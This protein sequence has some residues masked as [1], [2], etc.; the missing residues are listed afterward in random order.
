LAEISRAASGRRFRTA[1]LETNPPLALVAH[2][3]NHYVLRRKVEGIHSEEALGQFRGAPHLRE[4]NRALGMDRTLLGI[5]R[6]AKTWL[7]SRTDPAHREELEELV[8][9]VRWDLERNMPMVSVDA[10]GPS[11]DA[12]WIA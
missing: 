8:F 9:F 4:M 12:L 7:A 11:V 6:E 5:T 10:A 3:G 1:T 2:R